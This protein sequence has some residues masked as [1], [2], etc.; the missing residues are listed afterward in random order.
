MLICV[1]KRNI[2]CWQKWSNTDGIHTPMHLADLIVDQKKPDIF[3]VLA[4]WL[5]PAF[6]NF[7]LNQ[8]DPISTKI[9]SI[10]P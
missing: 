1:C 5:I 6:E 10:C 7:S 9:W 3:C 8:F 2:S 4:C